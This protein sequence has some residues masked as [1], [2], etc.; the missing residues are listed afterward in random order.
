MTIK[1]FD[2][3]A[4]AMARYSNYPEGS[5]SP[6]TVLA[7]L[8][9][10]GDPEAIASRVNAAVTQAIYQ[11]AEQHIKVAS[12]AQKRFGMFPIVDR[13]LEATLIAQLSADVVKAATAAI[14][15]T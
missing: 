4:L 11:R 3:A 9:M 8:P 6:R 14:G 2:G 1:T 15:Q 12:T 5:L 7:T 13:E 10:S